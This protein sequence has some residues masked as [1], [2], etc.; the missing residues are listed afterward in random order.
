MNSTG[1]PIRAKHL[2][3]ALDC[4]NARELAEFYARL[5]GWQVR[6]YDSPEWVSVIPPEGEHAA[7]EI[8]CQ[9]IEQYRR[10]TWPEG[11]VP[12]QAHLDFWVDSIAE[13]TPLALAAG[14]EVHPEQPGE[15][16]SWK[17]FLDPVGHLFCLCEN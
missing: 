10:P 16:Y 1:E 17:V 14:A 7:F 8:A 12:Q 13:A 2:V 6:T 9:Q 15:G 3:F 11:P 4:T 5:L